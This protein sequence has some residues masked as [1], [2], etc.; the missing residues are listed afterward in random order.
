MA[1]N[2]LVVDDD[3]HVR[4]TISIHLRNAGYDVRTAKDGIEGGYAVL[5]KRP[6]LM[7]LDVQ[8]PY[9]N[10][11]ELLAALRSDEETSMIP[12]IMV[13]T[14]MMNGMSVE[15]RSA[16]T[17]ASRS[18]STPTSCSSSWPRTSHHRQIRGNA[19]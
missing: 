13:T 5:R 18:R 1:R 2:V 10:G 9:M 11:F 8:M 15:I 19:F 6:D 12:V 17:A 16:L 4:D 7:I 14:G 3:P